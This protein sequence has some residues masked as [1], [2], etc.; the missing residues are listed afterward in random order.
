MGERLTTA[1][2]KARENVKATVALLGI[3]AVAVFAAGCGAGGAGYPKQEAEA[4]AKKDYDQTWAKASPAGK[5][6]MQYLAHSQVVILGD[7][8]H[9]NRYD[10]HG[11]VFSNGC[12]QNTA[13]D[14]AGGR[15]NG[16]FSGLFSSGSING[17]VPT[18]AA[19]AY[20]DVRKPDILTIQSG[21]AQSHDLR[22]KG[23]EGSTDHLTPLDQQTRNVLA[24]YGCMRA[25]EIGYT[26]NADG[27]TSGFI[28]RTLDDKAW[29]HRSDPSR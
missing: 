25:G 29:P 16:S 4:Y 6:I 10:Y 19:D 21:H 22:F 14:I 28:I 15:I 20:V 9:D 26:D 8:S 2:K 5:F 23:V 18:A 27:A 12:L 24:T 13:Y 3:G 11:F 1:T 7:T 17:R